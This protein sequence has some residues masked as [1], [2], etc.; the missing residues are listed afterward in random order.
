MMEKER[1]IA[2]D[3][4]RD[5][6]NNIIGFRDDD[7]RWFHLEMSGD[8]CYKVYDDDKSRVLWM[9]GDIKVTDF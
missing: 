4:F 1:H 6:T 9:R 7:G 2:K 8:D 3:R 5:P